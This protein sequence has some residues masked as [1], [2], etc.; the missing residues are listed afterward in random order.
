MLF[1]SHQIGND[2]SVALAE[3]VAG[4]SEI[5]ADLMNRT[6]QS[7]GLND[8]HF[9]NPTGLPD[10]SHYSS[11]RDMAELANAIIRDESAFYPLYAKKHFTWNN[12]RQ[13]NRNLLLWRDSTVDGLKTGHTQA[14]GY[15]MVTSAVRDGRRLIT[16][17]FG[18]T[19]TASRASDTQKLLTYGYRFYENQTLHTGAK[20]KRSIRHRCPVHPG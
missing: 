9:M 10:P 3:H 1:R 15:C 19:S 20:S 8:T 5:Y 6:A 12:I 2:A 17:V 16:A 18:S 13:A 4:S 14:A 11:A 7:L